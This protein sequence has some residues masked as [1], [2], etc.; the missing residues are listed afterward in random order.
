MCLAPEHPGEGSARHL[1]LRP[2]VRL[3]DYAGGTGF[4][5]W[6]ETHARQA[7]VLTAGSAVN[8]LLVE[9]TAD[10]RDMLANLAFSVSLYSGQLCTSPQN[11]LVPRAGITTDEGHKTF[12]EVVR[13]L[14]A[15]STRCSPTTP[16]PAPSWARSSRPPCG[17]AWSA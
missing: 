11:L 6:L 9:S 2:E 3:V 14:G 1:A 5:T 17:A 16:R 4:G 8:S 13:D 12:E 7:R 15:R 10:Y